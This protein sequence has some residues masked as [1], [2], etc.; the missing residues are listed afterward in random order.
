M[1]RARR[2]F[3]ILACL[4]AVVLKYSYLLLLEMEFACVVSQ[5]LK[6]ALLSILYSP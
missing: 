3:F 5:Y 6:G 1:L 2:M 4:V